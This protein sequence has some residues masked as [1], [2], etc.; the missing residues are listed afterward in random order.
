MNIKYKA[1]SILAEMIMDLKS[2][3]CMYC[4]CNNKSEPRSFIQVF[5]NP[6]YGIRFDG[7]Y[8]PP[9]I[10]SHFIKNVTPEFSPNSSIIVFVSIYL[11]PNIVFRCAVFRVPCTVYRVPCTVYR[12]PMNY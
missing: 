6:Y 10:L 4:S 7:N 5:S 1:Y 3:F 2:P 8:N 11:S 9:L 12:V